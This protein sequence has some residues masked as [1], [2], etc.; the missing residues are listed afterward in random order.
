ME[1]DMMDLDKIVEDDEFHPD[2]RRS[3]LM[4]SGAAVTCLLVFMLGFLVGRYF[5]MTHDS[6][7]QA[8]EAPSVSEEAGQELE[9]EA[10]VPKPGF[11]F[12][13][14]LSKKEPDA[15]VPAQKP[16]AP[17]PVILPAAD[18]PPPQSLPKAGPSEQAKTAGPPESKDA[19]GTE[20][21]AA[22]KI[23]PSQYTIQVG[24]FEDQAA[25]EKLAGYLKQ[26]GYPSYILMKAVSG[27]GSFHR[28]RI[29]RYSERAEAEQT[30][31]L[32]EEKEGAS[33]FITLYARQ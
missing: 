13:D 11:T 20:A 31:K 33:T 19:V 25:A 4:V 6:R 16:S 22:S 28:V 29:G 3:R 24:A 1:K 9:A 17:D 18:V 15:G 27:K 10:P 32:I 12:Y 7:K 14:E 5:P 2:N 23:I 8:V 26:K 30:A 21:V